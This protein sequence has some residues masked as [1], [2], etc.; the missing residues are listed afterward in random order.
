[1]YVDTEKCINSFSTV[2]VYDYSNVRT[3]LWFEHRNY[4]FVIIHHFY[5]TYVHQCIIYGLKDI[6]LS[7]GNSIS[8]LPLRWHELYTYKLKIHVQ[9][10]V[11]WCGADSSPTLVLTKYLTKQSKFLSTMTRPLRYWSGKSSISVTSPTPNVYGKLI[12]AAS[13]SDAMYG[14]L[15]SALSYV[16][17]VL[18]AGKAVSGSVSLVVMRMF[19]MHNTHKWL[20]SVGQWVEYIGFGERGNQ[21]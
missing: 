1:M 17:N 16:P 9:Q 20:Q 3:T 13:N 4:R 11:R 19:L 18:L 2:Y 12:P 10:C 21:D 6:I 5:L 14:T 7:I 15:S 8:P